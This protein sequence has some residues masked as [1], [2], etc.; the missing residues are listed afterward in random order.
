MISLPVGG[1]LRK[2]L[3]WDGDGLCLFAKRP[4]LRK[5]TSMLLSRSRRL[6]LI[7]GH[8]LLGKSGFRPDLGTP[9]SVQSL[10]PIM[11]SDTRSPD[12]REEVA[13]LFR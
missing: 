12:G 3:W 4:W 13:R 8:A 2:V 5:S 1:D 10:T 11:Q 7:P 6:P 9:N